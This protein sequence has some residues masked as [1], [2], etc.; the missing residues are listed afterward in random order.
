[1]SGE[2]EKTLANTLKA[3]PDL[4]GECFW[5]DSFIGV[6]NLKRAFD[7]EEICSDIMIFEEEGIK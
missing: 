4:L 6:I 1:M 2:E 5:A 7:S 3:L